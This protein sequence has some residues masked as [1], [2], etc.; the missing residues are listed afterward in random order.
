[1]PRIRYTL[2]TEVLNGNPELPAQG[3]HDVSRQPITLPQVRQLC[4]M[5]GVAPE[6]DHRDST[7]PRRFERD[8]AAREPVPLGMGN[9]FSQR[10]HLGESRSHLG[11]EGGDSDLGN[12][13]RDSALLDSEPERL[14][15]EG[16]L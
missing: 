13:D 10:R 9:E 11:D 12:R 6:V 4:E 3:L 5:I 16:D 1:M 8:E 15:R 2:K 14:G 7:E